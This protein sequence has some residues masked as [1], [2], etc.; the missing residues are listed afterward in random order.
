MKNALKI[1]LFSLLTSP[2]ASHAASDTLNIGIGAEFETLN[3]IIASQAATKYML[4]LATRPLVILSPDLKWVALNIK[5]IPTLDNGLVKKKGEGLDVTFEIRD[6]LQWG[7]G[8]PVTCQDIEFAWRVGRNKNVSIPSREPFENITAVTWDKAAPK[9]CTVA[10]AKAKFDYYN[11]IPDPMPTHLEEPVFKKYGSQAEGYDRN[12][13]YTK[14]P[15]NPGLY[16]GPYVISEVKFGSHVIFSAN[17]KWQGKKPYFKKIV[18]KL[19]PNNS[20]MEANLRSGNID[21]ISSAAGMGVDQAVA[22]E[23]KVKAENLPY[24]V[25]FEDGVTYAHIDLNLDNPILADLKVRQALS[26]GFNKKEMIDSLL[27]GKGRPAIH[28]VTERDPWYT[29]KVQI[30][31]PSK[32]QATKLLD[33]AGW[34]M[35]ADGYRH[36]NGKKMTLT[37]MAAA[38]AKINELIETYLQDKFKELGI[39]LLVKNEPARV[40]FG[41]TTPKRKFEMALYSWVSI[42]DNSPRSVLHST[43]IPSAK[44]SWAGQN[45]TGYKN[46]EVDK[47]ID[48]LEQELDAKKRA[49]I[50]KKVIE[51]Y[52]KDIP[53]I[54]MYYRATNAVIP[55]GLKNYRLSGHIFYET[56]AVEDWSL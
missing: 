33:E 16:F 22:F 23:R 13:L 27:E 53:V 39:E 21:M 46:A 49:D 36:K 54:P 55:K 12:T 35:G 48:A 10:M 7:D 37:L 44:N 38:G 3:P 18:F 50:G 2:L 11:N 47:L 51:F 41:E 5:E 32:R 26:H 8:V 52:A 24:A 43:S 9:K 29:D 17:P 14:N 30:Y 42:P 34:K 6:N 28:F 40:F 15:T 31:A 19:I 4:Y 20:T 1:A 25:P 45:F 56:L